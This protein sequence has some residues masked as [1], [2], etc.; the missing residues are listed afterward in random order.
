MKSFFNWGVKKEV[1]QL[2]KEKAK[3]EQEKEDLK[4]KLDKEIAFRKDL[5]RIVLE[6]THKISELEESLELN[7]NT[8]LNQCDLNDELQKK[9]NSLEK[10]LIKKDK[11]LEKDKVEKKELKAKIKGLEKELEKRYIVKTIKPTK[12][13]KQVMGLKNGSRQGEIIKKIKEN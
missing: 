10:E 6:D 5:G 8:L 13:T 1:E 11:Q 2:K 3:L 9:Y 12:P 7:K 4:N